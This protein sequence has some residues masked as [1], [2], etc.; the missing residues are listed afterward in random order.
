M[1][2]AFLTR[3]IKSYAL[4]EELGDSP[5]ERAESEQGGE[6]VESTAG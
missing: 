4:A 3:L 2:L 6:E 5:S 1:T